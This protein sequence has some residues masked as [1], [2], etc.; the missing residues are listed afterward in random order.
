M[1]SEPPSQET[2]NLEPVACDFGCSHGCKIPSIGHPSLAERAKLLANR[3]NGVA[4]AGP[5]QVSNRRWVRVN[6]PNRGGSGG[7][8]VLG[9]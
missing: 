1:L 3:A 5:E 6:R 8:A 2:G 4:R 7:L 9:V